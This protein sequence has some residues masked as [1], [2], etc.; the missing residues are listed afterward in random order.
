MSELFQT[1]LL[2]VTLAGAASA[3]AF[4]LVGGGALR[5]IVRMAAGC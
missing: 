5:E 3:V 2:R 4:R 1:I